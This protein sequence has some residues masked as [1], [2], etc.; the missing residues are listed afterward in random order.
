MRQWRHKAS[1][2]LNMLSEII[3]SATLG[4]VVMS[5]LLCEFS[6]LLNSHLA[7]MYWASF[8]LQV[9]VNPIQTG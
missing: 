7:G 8:Q 9:T 1:T 4:E 2:N 6:H 5:P 3:I